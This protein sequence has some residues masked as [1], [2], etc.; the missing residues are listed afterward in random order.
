MGDCRSGELN[1]ATTYSAAAAP[2]IYLAVLPGSACCC[3]LESYS[4]AGSW[5][6]LVL[7]VIK[8]LHPASPPFGDWGE[9]RFTVVRA[10]V[11]YDIGELLPGKPYLTARDSPPF[12]S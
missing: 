3:C 2:V 10:W 4:F 7:K 5:L 9:R 6:H 12:D 8:N 1:L 11:T